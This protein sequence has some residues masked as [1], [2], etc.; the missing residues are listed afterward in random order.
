[1]ETP[2]NPTAM[3]TPLRQMRD[4]PGPRGWP[5]IGNLVQMRPARI[6]LDMERWSQRYG[7][8][9]RVMFGRRPVLVLADHDTINA[10]LRNRPDGFERPSITR[11]ISEELGGLPGVFLAEGATWRNQR[12][13]V[14]AGF[15]PHAIKAYFPSLVKVALRM[16][17]RW[18]DAAASGRPI[19]LLDDLKRYTVDII[20]GLA[21]GTEVNTIDGGEDV[22]QRHLD[23]IMLGVARRSIAVFPRW[24]YFKLPSDRRLEHSVQVLREEIQSLIAAA[25]QRMDADPSRRAHPPNL[26]EAMIAA[27]DEGGSG[28]DDVAVAGNV[29]T[30]LLAGEDTTSNSL[31]W[32]LYLLHRHPAALQH[33]RDEVRALAPDT[34]GFT[35][36]QMDSLDY[37]DACVHEAMRL[38]PVAP[39]L[40]LEALKETTVGDVLLPKGG[41]VWC[42]MRHDSVDPSKVP[43]AQDFDPERWLRPDEN[44]VVKRLAQP[45]GAGLRTCPGRYLALLEIKIAAAMLLSSFELEAVDTPDGGP[46]REMM[47]FVMSPDGLTMRLRPRLPAAAPQ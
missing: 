33:V 19:D 30:M 24:R 9:F 25:R 32:L 37:L 23:I 2:I 40:P 3:E 39:F 44:T 31:A 6:H 16:Q 14:M 21:F 47:G 10:V 18:R 12:R 8:L 34:A 45:F 27:A 42:I 36:E 28:V 29:S 20:A 46:A 1:M 41:L 13:M 11:I 22:I 35:I 38:H 17:T 5:L 4:L 15:A 43:Q 26:L 7:T